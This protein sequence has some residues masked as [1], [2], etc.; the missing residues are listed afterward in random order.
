MKR[1]SSTCLFELIKVNEKTSTQYKFNPFSEWDRLFTKKEYFSS[2]QLK[3]YLEYSF[4]PFQ[5]QETKFTKKK[6]WSFLFHLIFKL[7]KLENEAMLNL[8]WTHK[9]IKHCWTHKK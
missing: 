7:S 8:C 9:I 6:L 4:L 5:T 2:T 3:G 1:L